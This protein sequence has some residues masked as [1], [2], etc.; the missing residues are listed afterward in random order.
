MSLQV[1]NGSFTVQQIAVLADDALRLLKRLIATPSLSGN[2]NETA[3]YIQLFI[4]NHGIKTHRLH[5]NVWAFNKYFNKDKPTILLNSHHD[6]VKPNEGYSRNPYYPQIIDGKLYGLGSNDAGGCL[7]ALLAVFIRFYAN[8][9]LPYNLCF[10]ATAE[11]ENSGINGLKA[12]LPEIGKIAF[13]L[14][15]EPTQMQMATAEMGCI[16]LDCT[17]IGVAG[18]AARNEGDNALYKALADINWFSAYQFPKQSAFMGPVKMTVTE[19]NAG[20]QH[21]IIPHECHFTVDVRLSDCYSTGE[22]LSIIKEHTNCRVDTRSGILKPSCI[23][24]LHPIVRAG[25][26]IGLKTYISPTSS[27]QGWMDVPSLKM[28]PGD[29]ARSHMPNEYIFVNEIAE[30]INIYI[31]LLNSLPF[32][33]INNPESGGILTNAIPFR[34]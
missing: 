13:A 3:D 6:T 10:A 33:L 19:I 34:N 30:G 21:N 23:N 17:T 7:V 31:R 1:I 26:A 28:G 9:D 11:E 20:V 15:G 24:H 25:V 14:V 22:V 29:S 2:E 4:K 12:I 27:D 16:V 8:P 18:H 5:N 32:Y